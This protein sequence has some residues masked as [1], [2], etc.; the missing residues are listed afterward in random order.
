[1]NFIAKCLYFVVYW[2]LKFSSHKPTK[3]DNVEIYKFDFVDSNVPIVL[4]YRNRKV[5]YFITA[6]TMEDFEKS[7]YTMI[8]FNSDYSEKSIT[9]FQNGKVSK[10]HGPA[11][12]LYSS[13]TARN[14]FTVCFL[15]N[16]KYHRLD[17]PACISKEKSEWWVDGIELTDSVVNHFSDIKNIDPDDLRVFLISEVEKYK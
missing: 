15:Y 4:V 2:G 1:M 16:G 7:T 10:T 12:K 17:G 13:I 11:F 5:Y 6:K 14:P 8:M 3:F 9:H